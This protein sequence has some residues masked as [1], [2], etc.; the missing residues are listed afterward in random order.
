[1][2]AGR[3]FPTETCQ[4]RRR[5]AGLFYGVRFPSAVHQ[6]DG[7]RS[8][9]CGRPLIAPGLD[10]SAAAS[11]RDRVCR[12]RACAGRLG[13]QVKEWARR[14][15]RGAVMPHP[16]TPLKLRERLPLSRLRIDAQIA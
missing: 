12:K 1:M 11:R 2:A 5:L 14:Y 3:V 4:A 13:H 16:E 6:S 8:E 10:I 7:A 9:N 15:W